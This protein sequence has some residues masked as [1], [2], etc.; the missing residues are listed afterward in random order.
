MPSRVDRRRWA[1]RLVAGLAVVAIAAGRAGAAP[2]ATW[3]RVLAEDESGL[4]LLLVAPEPERTA[5]GLR[6]PGFVGGGDPGDPEWFE[7]ALTIAVPGPGGAL[8]EVLGSRDRDLGSVPRRIMPAPRSLEDR[9]ADGG[10]GR[11]ASEWVEVPARRLESPVPARTVELGGVARLRER[12]VVTLHFRPV[13]YRPDGGATWTSEVRVRLRWADRVRRRSTPLDDPLYTALFNA[14]SAAF[15]ETAPRPPA[16]PRRDTAALPAERLRIATP[17]HGIY[18]L[19]YGDLLGA[20]VPVGS[21]SFDPQ[22]LRLFFDSW[23]PVPLPADSV[24][25]SWQPSWEM[26]EAALWFDDVAGNGS[27][28]SGDRLVFYALGPQ[29]YEDVAGTSADSLTWFRHPYDK[30][31]YAW[32]TWGGEFGQRMATESASVPGGSGAPIIGRNWHRQH[33]EEDLSYSA[34]DDLWYWEEVRAAR[35]VTKSISVGLAGEPTAATTMHLLLGSAPGSGGQHQ[36]EVLVN[37]VLVGTANFGAGVFGRRFVY[38]VTLQNGANTLLLRT[39]PDDTGT[40]SYLLEFDLF[41]DRP[42]RAFDTNTNPRL[43]WST[44]PAAPGPVI[45]EVAGFAA[46]APLV[47]DVTDPLHPV[48]LLGPTASGSGATTAWQVYQEAADRSRRHYLAVRAPTDVPARDLLRRVVAP[49]REATTC[50]DML[51]VTHS[52]LR[53]AADRLAAHRRAHWPDGGQPDIR[54]VTV[55]D[56]YESFSGGRVDPLAI[57]NY[58]KLLYGLES[59]P[60][61]RYVLLFGDG[62]Y[63]MRQLLGGSPATLVPPF[64]PGYVHPNYMRLGGTYAVED[65]FGEMQTPGIGSPPFPLPDVAVGRLAARTPAEAE[66]LVDKVIAYE[67]TSGFGT[68]RARLLMTAD[69]E[70]QLE[71]CRESYH[72]NN[73]EN[74]C[75]QVPRDLDVVKFYLTEYP[76][77]LGQKPQAR[78]AFI[79]TW[80]EGCVLVNYQGHGAPRQ[81][82][83]EVLFLS[84]D[85][86]ALTNGSKLPIFLPISCTVSE[87]DLPEQQSMCEDL[88]AAAAGGAIASIGATTPTYVDPN[89]Y[90][91]SEVFQKLFADGAASHVPLGLVHQLAKLEGLMIHGGYNETYVLLADPAMSLVLPHALVRFT[92]GADTL[93]TGNRARIEG[94]V[95]AAADSSLLAG[96]IGQAEVEVRGTNDTSGYQRPGFVDIDYDLPG[97]PLYR[98]TVPVSGGRFAFDFI[99]PLGA[100]AG[101]LARVN[102]YASSSAL[103]GRGEIETVSIRLAAPSDSSLGPPRIALRFPN[104]RTRIKA[105]TPLNAEIRDENGINIQ[106]TSLRTS[107]YLDFDRRNEPLDVTGQ[108]RYAAGSDSVGGLTVPLPSDLESGPHSATL[109]ASDNLLNTGTASLEFQVVESEIV[110]MVNVLAFPNPFRDWTQF[111]F[112]I[113]DPADVEVRVFTTSGREVWHHRQRFEAATQGSIKWDGVDLQ[114]DTLANG[115]YVYRLRAKPDRAGTPA[116]EHIGKVVIMR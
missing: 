3:V 71:S 12:D 46:Q 109:I 10:G 4:E 62:N 21:Q 5:D 105:G 50:P 38:P 78:A 49:L 36:I 19:G 29:G 43:G 68:W 48:R 27:F 41:F 22:T 114:E 1:M 81:L 112:E 28:D 83:D 95:I 26:Q 88:L 72:T 30:N 85:I 64:E 32:L 103:D 47:F 76:Y 84:T 8:L 91:N 20:G 104:N 14:A 98:G 51:I 70:C 101:E 67:T 86:P 17:Q 93:A 52:S 18:E 34:T 99:V 87:F 74:L 13:Q 35:A 60:P 69:D 102:A 89:Y 110:Q 73:T 94:E 92:S 23:K 77:Q 63:D 7:R 111:F 6:L 42:L 37:N 40:R 106:G 9:R 24:P 115:T 45:Y 44:R 96:F 79:R 113:T 97:P 15:W 57:R 75:A 61:L 59:P 108:F 16:A 100:Q 65:W 31:A 80:S 39:G 54:V 82:A 107:I 56:I 11:A 53:A 116:L 33:H 2:G 55:S 58:V 90:F 25:S 66:R